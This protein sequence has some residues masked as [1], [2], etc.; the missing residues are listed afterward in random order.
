LP[1]TAAKIWMNSQTKRYDEP[2]LEPEEPSG[3]ISLAVIHPGYPQTSPIEIYPLSSDQIE[4]VKKG[5]LII[6]IVGV[7]S[8]DDG[9]GRNRRTLFCIYHQPGDKAGWNLCATGNKAE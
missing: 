8:Y 3:I 4:A 9:F 2:G 5:V 1:A 6:Y 7:V